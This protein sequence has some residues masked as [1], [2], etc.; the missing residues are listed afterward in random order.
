MPEH[1]LYRG[2]W[3]QNVSKLAKYGVRM[4]DREWKVTVN[5]DLGEG[6]M[7][8]AVEGGDSDIVDRVNQIKEAADGQSGGVFYINEY[9][10]LIVPVAR[11]GTSHYFY[12]GPVEPTFTFEFEGSPLTN[13]PVARDG[14]ALSPGDPWAGPRPGIPY[15]LAAGGNDIYFETPALTDT[16]PPSV[17]PGVTRQ[18]KLSKVLRDRALVARAVRVI[19]E[20]RGHQG[21]RFYVNEHGSVFT[22]VDRGD[23][24]GLN[25]IYCG[26]I[27]PGAWFPEPSVP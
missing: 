21:G 14:E 4:I 9:H 12:G 25:Y 6:L 20:V 26:Q 11:D 15:V 18:V 13:R 1:L 23:G 22:P 17:R 8:L 16:D 7:H 24:N 27:D 3:P 2:L 10:H 5:Y 19:R